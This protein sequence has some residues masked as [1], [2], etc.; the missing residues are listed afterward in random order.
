MTVSGNDWEVK[1]SHR[2]TP[3]YNWGTET[4][5]YGDMIFGQFKKHGGIRGYKQMDVNIPGVGT[6]QYVNIIL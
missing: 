6:F 1:S 3:S 4:F 5:K 2:L